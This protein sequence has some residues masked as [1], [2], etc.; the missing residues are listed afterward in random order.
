MRENRRH[1]RI[2]FHLPIGIVG[3]EGSHDIRNFS[4]G[5]LF[6]ETE[7]CPKVKA[8][9]HMV[10][11]LKLPLEEHPMLVSPR[12]AHVTG[13]GVGVEFVNLAPFHT[14]FMLW[15]L[16]GVLMFSSILSRCRGFEKE[17]FC[18]LRVRVDILKRLW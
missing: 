12:I 2:D 3:H 15:L 1:H 14:P 4:L 7:A 10:L 17:G 11:I 9:D 16:N 5:G 6:V 18:Y 8:G 13:K